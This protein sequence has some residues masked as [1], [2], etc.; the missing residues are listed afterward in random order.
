VI[1]GLD[2]NDASYN[3]IRVNGG[4]GG[5]QSFIE[6]NVKPVTVNGNSSNDFDGLGNGGSLAGILAP[7]TLNN[8]PSFS[9]VDIQDAADNTHHGNV[10]L[11]ASSLTNLAPAAINI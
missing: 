8:G 2:F 5:T 10:V 3:S 1:N 11:T 4:A 9:H 6:A 7:V